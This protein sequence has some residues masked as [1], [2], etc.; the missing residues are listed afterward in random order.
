MS[1]V[2]QVVCEDG[3]VPQ[4]L[5]LSGNA[6]QAL[7]GNGTFAD[8]PV[9]P[10]IQSAINAATGFGPGAEAWPVGSVFTAVVATN[11]ATLLGYGTWS[12]LAAGR[13]L[14]GLD[15][16]NPAFD[17]AEE[18]GGA[19]T[20]AS[21]GSNAAE[22]SHTHGYTEVPNHTHPFTI[23]SST[24]DGTWASFDSSTT[25]G[26]ARNFATANPTGGVA[27][28]TTLAGSSH[29]HA[30]TG[31]ATSVVQPYLVVYFWKR[32]A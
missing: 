19:L 25:A 28:G 23:N 30:F 7:L 12:A 16:G 29:T 15:V 17:A 11:P 10:A 32:T 20:V 31:S 24:T 26:T 3:T 27:Q 8:V 21:A 2:V 13:V 5:V 1:Y 6:Q 18:T 9:S 4:R 22:A 14:V